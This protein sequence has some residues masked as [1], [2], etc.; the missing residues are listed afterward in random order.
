MV[1]EWLIKI[2]DEIKNHSYVYWNLEAGLGCWGH[3]WNGCPGTEIV[4]M[5]SIRYMCKENNPK[6]YWN[7]YINAAVKVLWRN[8]KVNTLID[9]LCTWINFPQKSSKVAVKTDICFQLSSVFS[10]WMQTW[11]HPWRP[12]CSSPRSFFS[13]SPYAYVYGNVSEVRK[14]K[15]WGCQRLLQSLLKTTAVDQWI[16]YPRAADPKGLLGSREGEMHGW[17][18]CTLQTTGEAFCALFSIRKSGKRSG[19]WLYVRHSFHKK[20]KL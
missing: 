7:I 5:L 6:R 10:A 8:S 13:L 4:P 20:N 19:K 17:L 16:F 1:Q 9:L 3:L 11:F 18:S 12:W 15:I 2:E 14:F